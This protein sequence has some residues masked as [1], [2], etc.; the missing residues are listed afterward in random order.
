MPDETTH[1]PCNIEAEEAAISALLNNPECISVANTILKPEYFY[2]E[3]NRVIFEAMQE[4]SGLNGGGFDLTSIVYHLQETKNDKA[5]VVYINRLFDQFISPHAIRRHAQAI[6]DTAHRREAIRAF[7]TAQEQLQNGDLGTYEILSNL[8][9]LVNEVTTSRRTNEPIAEPADRLWETLGP[10]PEPLVDGLLVPSSCGFIGADAGGG[11]TTTSDS[12]ALSVATGN[13]AF[14]KFHVPNPRNVLLIQVEDPKR[15]HIKRLHRLAQGMG[16]KSLPSN[17]FRWSRRMFFLDDP[18]DIYDL[19]LFIEENDIGLV[20]ADPFVYL[21]GK[22]ENSNQDMGNLLLPIKIMF[23]SLNCSLAIIHHN[24]HMDPKYRG[25]V[26]IGRLRGASFLLGWRDF[27]LVLSPRGNQVHV[28]SIN[29]DLINQEF[30]LERI[31]DAD[32]E[33]ERIEWR[34]AGKLQDR[35]Y[36]AREKL[37]ASI[38]KLTPAFENEK[39]RGWMPLKVVRDDAGIK[40]RKTATDRAMEL[41]DDGRIYIEPGTGPRKPTLVKLADEPSDEVDTYSDFFEDEND[42]F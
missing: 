40:T 30:M 12:L 37:Y 26:E 21:H 32:G 42:A 14:D 4:L 16:L 28:R 20:I 27:Y 22:D 36:S 3:S 11:K 6:A 13:K 9:N 41:V 8:T 19:Q 23:S 38:V 24:K 15:R 39:R 10:D 33:W 5:D 7:R 1:P 34:E 18:R 29:K 35:A 25:P 2:R 31:A 17:L